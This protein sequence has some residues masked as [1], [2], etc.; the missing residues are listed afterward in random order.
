[1]RPY[2][3][4]IARR[5]RFQADPRV[6]VVDFFSLPNTW[7]KRRLVQRI[8]FALKHNFYQA[9]ILTQT[10]AYIIGSLQQLPIQLT[11]KRNNVAQSRYFPMLKI[12]F[13]QR[14]RGMHSHILARQVKCYTLF[15]LDSY[16][17]ESGLFKTIFQLKLD[18]TR[19]HYGHGMYR[20]FS[21]LNREPNRQ[22]YIAVYRNT[23][24]SWHP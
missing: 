5:W 10:G 22:K 4:P 12:D 14:D 19:D 1:M 3:R 6:H 23:E 9:N 20:N 7:R 17:I 18:D 16:L 8:L 11:G 15:Q 21:S 2:F 13:W 24:V